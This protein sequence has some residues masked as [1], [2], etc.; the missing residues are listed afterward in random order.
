MNRTLALGLLGGL[1]AF[2]PHL[3]AQGCATASD[4][5]WQRDTLPQVSPNP[6]AVSVIQG[7]DEGE[8]AGVVFEMPASMGPQIVTQVVAPWGAPGG[9]AGLNALLDVEVYD[10]VQFTG[11][12]LN[13]GTRVFSLSQNLSANMQVSSHGFNVLDTST[14]NIVVGTAPPNGTP[15]VRRFAIC[16]RVDQNLHPTGS[17]QNG[18]PANFFTDNSLTTI[19]C[20]SVITPAQ[21]SIIE[22]HD[23]CGGAYR[24]WWDV[25]NATVTGIPICGIYYQGIWAIRCCTRDAFPASYSIFGAGCAGSLGTSA[26]QNLSLPQIGQTLDVRIT[27]LPVNIAIMATGFS[28]TVSPLGS[29]PFAMASLGAPGCFARVSA[30]STQ[31]LA[32]TNNRAF[33]SLT[34]PNTPGLIGLNLYQQAFAID[35]GV[36]ALGATLSDAAQLG[37]GN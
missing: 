10:G 11:G 15:F 23:T 9:I 8:S 13:M 36:N 21:T 27:N 31:F 37:V 16:F 2:T 19:F 25:T 28:N 3:A 14:Y 32:G 6:T 33:W 4:T 34:L 1:A 26:L 20:N 35:P 22:Y 5:W 7:L 12:Q 29:L 18:W 30:D 24:G 17:C